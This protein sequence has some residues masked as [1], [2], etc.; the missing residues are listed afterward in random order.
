MIL[1]QNI[2]LEDGK[3][4]NIGILDLQ[5]SV[6]EHVKALLNLKDINIIRVKYLDDIK[7]I[8]GLIIPGGEST[9]LGK[10]L[11]DFNL[12]EPIK[13]KI[14][15]G[16]PVW[17]TC[18]GLILLAKKI[19]NSNSNYIS[20]M[21]I[22]VKRNAYG[23]QL[24]SF[25]T[26]DI[27]KGISN[28]PIK[29]VFIRAPYILDV[30]DNVTTLKTVNNKIIAARQDNMLVTSFHPE[31]TNDTSVHKYFIDMVGNSIQKNRSN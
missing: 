11:R 10:L 8:Q 1:K 4:I 27:I 13:N 22:N 3:M 26:E 16:M 5:G 9:T 18:A 14:L 6:D 19:E 23:T 30:H 7:N 20:T 24:D 29:M 28:K 12:L 2:L 31:L 21:G 17:G 15:R 25:V